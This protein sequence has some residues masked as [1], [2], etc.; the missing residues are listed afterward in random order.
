MD[1]C[2]E[3][4]LQNPQ[5]GPTWMEGKWASLTLAEDN[6]SSS[7]KQILRQEEPASFNCCVVTGDDD[8]DNA[9]NERDNCFPSFSHIEKITTWQDPRKAM[10]QPLNHMN[11]HPA[12]TSTP[13]P[14][15]SMAVSQPNLGKL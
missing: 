13:A 10:N 3:S 12:A 2:S 11:L 4:P 1:L 8:I 7:Y 15:R 9:N 5:R 6:V 14:Q